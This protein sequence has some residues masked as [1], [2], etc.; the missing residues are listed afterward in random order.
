MRAWVMGAAWAVCSAAPMDTS[1]GLLPPATRDKSTGVARIRRAL[2]AHDLVLA[3]KEAEELARREPA[4]FEPLFWS[5]YLDLL[6]DRPYDA[7]RA[8]RRAERLD[9]NPFVL[10]LLAVSYGSAHQEGLFLLKMRAALEKD[11]SDF[12]PYYYLGRYYDSE[13]VD[14]AR[15]A[16]YL[17]QALARRPDHSRAHYYLGHSHEME[18]RLDQAEAEYRKAVEG[19]EHAGSL[20]YQGLAR[21]RLAGNRPVEA[22]AFAQRAV[23]IAP[24]DAAGHKVLARVYSD[25]GRVAEALAEWRASILLDPTDASV[26]YRL[27]RGYLALGQ[28]ENAKAALAEYKKIAGLYGTN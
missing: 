6:Q 1:D 21:L 12:A 10:K 25:L 22:L 19:A 5:G 14:F 26:R 8:L 2:A 3:S 15:A 16:G 7:V 23:K 4:S 28:A 20:P 11:P 24:R 18:Q 13:M 27:Y 9:P 17:Q